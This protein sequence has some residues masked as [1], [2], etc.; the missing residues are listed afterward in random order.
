MSLQQYLSLM[1]IATGV[2]YIVFASVL[3]YF[4]PFVSGIVALVLFYASLSLALVGTLSLVGFFVRRT[5]TPQTIAFRDVVTSFRQAVLLS[6]LLV[7]SL[8]LQQFN[9]LSVW[10]V[11]GLI[12]LLT[13][14][15]L[16]SVSRKS[17]TLR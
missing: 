1:A 6:V 7:T 13:G 14:I 10:L 11:I 8:V 2:S 4:D 12:V 17:Q 3:V 16:Y 15:E 9:V 5:T